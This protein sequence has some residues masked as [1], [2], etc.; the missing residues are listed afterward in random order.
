MILIYGY[1]YSNEEVEK[2]CTMGADLSKVF[3]E[4]ICNMVSRETCYWPKLMPMMPWM[5]CKTVTCTKIQI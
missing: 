1:M 5:I 2:M 4:A 3:I